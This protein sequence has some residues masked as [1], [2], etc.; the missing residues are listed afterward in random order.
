MGC[1]CFYRA[2][3]CFWVSSLIQKLNLFSLIGKHSFYIMC[4]HFVTFAFIN[5]ILSGFKDFDLGWEMEYSSYWFIYCMGG[6][7]CAF[8]FK[9][10]SEFFEKRG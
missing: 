3:L 5:V 4:F 6:G 8:S 1:V 10:T 2:M 7:I 9:F